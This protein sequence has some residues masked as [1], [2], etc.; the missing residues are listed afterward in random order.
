MCHW[1]CLP[2]LGFFFL[3]PPSPLWLK[4]SKQSNQAF[5]FPHFQ[6][7][8]LFGDFSEDVKS[9]WVA[10]C[11]APSSEVTDVLFQTICQKTPKDSTKYENCKQALKEVSKVCS[12]VIPGYFQGKWMFSVHE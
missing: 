4:Q 1:G 11:A 2:L 7:C 9:L 8:F 10:I 5:Y 6:F 3:M 12:H